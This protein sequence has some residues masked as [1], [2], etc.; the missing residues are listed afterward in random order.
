MVYACVFTFSYCSHDHISQGPIIIIV[1]TII[2]TP[3]MLS[4]INSI[5]IS[6]SYTIW[7]TLPCRHLW[8]CPPIVMTM[9]IPTSILPT[10]ICLCHYQVIKTIP[11]YPLPIPNPLAPSWA[12]SCLNNALL[13]P[14]TPLHLVD[15]FPTPIPIPNLTLLQPSFP[16]LHQVYSW[17]F[18]GLATV[19]GQSSI[20]YLPH[21]ICPSLSFLALYIPVLSPVHHTF[22]YVSS[23]ATL[24]SFLCLILSSLSPFTLVFIYLYSIPLLTLL[25]Y[26]VL[27]L[28]L[29][30]NHSDHPD[31]YHTPYLYKYSSYKLL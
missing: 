14:L 4:L 21:S 7:S 8:L 22:L 18:I 20:T 25:S 3:M 27:S 30:P 2:N 6:I 16:L 24:C 26:P 12:S 13:N 11:K 23:F 5:F 17:W 10:P 29:I 9:T 19:V 1:S 28:R 15:T 31:P